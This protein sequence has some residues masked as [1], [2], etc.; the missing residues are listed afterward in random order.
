[1]GKKHNMLLCANTSFPYNYSFIHS[2]EEDFY[3][4]RTN[5]KLYRIVAT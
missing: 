4:Q 3:E 5:R 2:E 1:M